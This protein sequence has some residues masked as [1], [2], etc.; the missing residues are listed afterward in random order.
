MSN[1]RAK[2]LLRNAAKTHNDIQTRI[3]KDEIRQRINEIK[4]LS[5]QEDVPKFSLRKEVLHLEQKLEGVF[6]I[7]AR[8][9]KTEK[10]E[11][12]KINNLRKQI[13]M[14]RKR[15]EKAEDKDLQRKLHRLSNILSEALAKNVTAKDVEIT[16]K[17]ANA[18]SEADKAAETVV[19]SQQD[20]AQRMGA[21]LQRIKVMHQELEIHKHMDEVDPEKIKMLGD[22]IKRIEEACKQYTQQLEIKHTDLLTPQIEN[23]KVEQD[24]KEP[25]VEILDDLKDLPLPPPPRRHT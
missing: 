25:E 15:L 20:T 7:E 5:S 1:I 3:S 2:Q 21:I 14:L 11:E 9:L 18:M 23:K 17:L 8:L 4:Y 16:K 10:R 19:K 24:V 22:R 12:S 13:V 6:N